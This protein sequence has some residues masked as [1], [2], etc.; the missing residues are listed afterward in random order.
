MPVIPNTCEALE[1]ATI[2]RLTARFPGLSVELYPDEPESYRLDHP[3]GALLVRYAGSKYGPLMDT[4]I[5]V[6]ERRLGLEVTLV[7][8]S[9]HGKD[10]ITEAL[11][12]VRLALAGYAPPAFGK[13]VPVSDEFLGEHGGEWRYAIDFVTTTTVIEDE[14]PDLSPR[15]TRLTFLGENPNEPQVQVPRP[16]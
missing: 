7:M 15:S 6:Q 12:Q 1:R 4:N 11:E 10:G 8:R 16:D 3:V 9:L 13:F 5:V 14:E 2:E